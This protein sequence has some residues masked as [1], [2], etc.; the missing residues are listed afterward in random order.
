MIGRC[1]V[2]VVG[3]S[4]LG[5]LYPPLIYVSSIQQINAVSILVFAGR[6]P[7]ARSRGRVGKRRCVCVCQVKYIL[8]KGERADG[9]RTH[10]DQKEEH[11]EEHSDGHTRT[12]GSNTNMEQHGTRMPRSH[13]GARSQ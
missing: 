11:T 10:G 6:R 12:S 5:L 1:C 8:N 4:T 2:R 7:A 3:F 13:E 9:R